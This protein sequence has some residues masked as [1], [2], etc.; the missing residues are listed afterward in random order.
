[1]VLPGHK[2]W[3]TTLEAMGAAIGAAIFWGCDAMLGCF[4]TCLIILDCIILWV[5]SEQTESSSSCR[6]TPGLGVRSGLLMLS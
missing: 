5:N 3:E 1:M 2:I 4:S 6:W